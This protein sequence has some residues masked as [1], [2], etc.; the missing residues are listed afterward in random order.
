MV[1]ARRVTSKKTKPKPIIKLPKNF[2]QRK[3]TK[4]QDVYYVVMKVRGKQQKLYPKPLRLKDAK[5]YLAYRLDKGLSR[6]AWFE[7]IGRTKKVIIPPKEVKG[8][9][10][11][12]KKKLRPY[13]IRVGKK[14]ALRN[15][16]IEKRKYIMDTRGE[17]LQAQRARKKKLVKKKRITKRRR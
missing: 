13:R 1:V 16:F 3:L 4:A 2:K 15:G 8:Y 17:K 9:Y 10:I 12:N 14:K 6:T 5:D 7:P 11:R